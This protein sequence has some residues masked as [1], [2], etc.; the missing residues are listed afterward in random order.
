MSKRNDDLSGILSVLAF[1]AV[2]ACCIPFIRHEAK[3]EKRRRSKACRFK[4]SVSEDDFCAIVKSAGSGLKNLVSLYS[5]GTDVYGIVRSRSGISE[6]KFKVDFNDYGKLT[7]KYWITSENS[8]SQI[9]KLVADRIVSAI[10][11][12]S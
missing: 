4:G 6:W 3:E 10:V 5:E 2:A 9:P 12:N 7:G 8:D 11:D 1:G